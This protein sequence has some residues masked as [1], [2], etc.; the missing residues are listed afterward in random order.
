MHFKS[1]TTPK[2]EIHHTDLS[3]FSRH[4]QSYGI[5]MYNYIDVHQ[6]V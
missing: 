2:M 5:Y 3:F 1:H 6:F 4:R